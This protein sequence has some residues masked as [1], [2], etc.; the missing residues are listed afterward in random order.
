MIITFF[1]YNNRLC[2]LFTPLDPSI[3]VLT[4]WVVTVVIAVYHTMYAE[5]INSIHKSFA[6]IF[7]RLFNGNIRSMAI[8]HFHEYTFILHA[9][10]NKINHTIQATSNKKL[11]VFIICY[12]ARPHTQT[13]VCSSKMILLSWTLFKR[14]EYIRIVIIYVTIVTWMRMRERKS[15]FRETKFA[16]RGWLARLI[17]HQHWHLWL[18]NVVVL[19][20]GILAFIIQKGISEFQC[21]DRIV[22]SEN[23]CLVCAC[24]V[25]QYTQCSTHVL[26]VAFV[27]IA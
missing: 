13:C 27:V 4:A 3:S 21:F 15:C 6:W 20:I 17:S 5:R 22:Y 11:E 16:V 19:F 1:S 23:G 24:D 10:H 18:L 2:V 26:G 12:L 25:V 14:A 8:G 7:H 9:E